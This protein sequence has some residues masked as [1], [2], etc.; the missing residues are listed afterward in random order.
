MLELINRMV[1]RWIFFAQMHSLSVVSYVVIEINFLGLCKKEKSS[2]CSWAKKL[3]KLD[4]EQ[5]VQ[6]YHKTS[7]KKKV[8]LSNFCTPRRLPCPLQLQIY[9]Y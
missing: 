9:E 7:I 4:E 8:D 3:C 5:Y 6:Q 1:V 2:A